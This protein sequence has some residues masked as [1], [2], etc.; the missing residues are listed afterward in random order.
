MGREPLNWKLDYFITEA[1][2]LFRT[3][4]SL[5]AV[6]NKEDAIKTNFSNNILRFRQSYG[7]LYKLSVI[8]LPSAVN[9]C[10]LISNIQYLYVASSFNPRFAI[11][12]LVLQFE[13]PVKWQKKGVCFPRWL[14]GAPVKQNISVASVEKQRCPTISS[15]L[16]YTN[17][18]IFHF[19]T[20]REG[21]RGNFMRL[22]CGPEGCGEKEPAGLAR[23]CVLASLNS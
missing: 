5:A 4:T 7:A 11:C 15:L 9:P 20:K 19:G 16:N 22:G 21:S 14:D 10:L 23:G 12:K 18:G 17:I 13:R 3:L 2:K 6:G 1:E 8:P